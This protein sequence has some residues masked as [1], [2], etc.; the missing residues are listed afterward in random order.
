M[1]RGED[2]PPPLSNNVKVAMTYE[3]RLFHAQRRNANTQMRC[4]LKTKDDVVN[5]RDGP[6]LS[7]ACAVVIEIPTHT[8]STYIF[9]YNILL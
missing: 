4:S 2:T 6:G 7:R 1:D 5:A 8:Y 3:S 9:E